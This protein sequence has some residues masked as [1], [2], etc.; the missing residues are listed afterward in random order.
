MILEIRLV[1][2]FTCKFLNLVSLK[3]KVIKLLDCTW[4]LDYIEVRKTLDIIWKLK[5]GSLNLEILQI[6]NSWIP[7][8]YRTNFRNWMWTWITVGF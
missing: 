6:R 5:L 4:K 8:L 2:F 3:V 1:E 7:S